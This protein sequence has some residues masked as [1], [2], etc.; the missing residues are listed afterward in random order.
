M[1]R[2]K[3]WKF[4]VACLAMAGILQGTGAAGGTMAAY[5]QEETGADA[6]KDLI[7]GLA[8]NQESFDP[9]TAET[10]EYREPVVLARALFDSLGEDEQEELANDG[11]LEELEMAEAKVLNLWIRDTPLDAV[12]DG[13][14]TWIME[15][16]YD[17]LV[18]ALGEETAAELI[19]L[20]ET[21]FL[22]YN[23]LVPQFQ[24]EKR[25]NLEEGL[26][27][28]TLIQEMDPE[29][30][31]AV[32]Q[33]RESYDALTEMQQAYV[34]H[35]S[36]LKNAEGKLAEAQG[37]AAEDTD[38][39]RV[40]SSGVRSSV[41]GL[42]DQWLLPEQWGEITE[43]MQEW[44]PASQPVL[45]WIVGHLSD[46]GCTL[47]F[48]PSQEVDTEQLAEQY[49]Y[50]GEP[51]RNNHL[52]HEE[53]FDYFDQHGIKV[54]LQ[55][56]PGFADVDTL[57]DL[58]LQQY[59]DHECVAGCGVDV[60]WYYGIT[61]DSG[62][63]V[64]DALAEKWDT[65]LK[66]L[67][68]DYRLFLKH[69]N[70]RYLPSTYRSDILF[71]D[72]SQG[73]GSMIGDVLGIYDENVDDVLGFV[74]E[75]KRFADAFPE[76]EVLYQIGYT[77]DAAWYN[78]LEDPVVRSLGLRLAEVTKQNCGIIWVDFSIK[79]PMTFPQTMTKDDKTNA[80][81][82]LLS[83]L[84]PSENGG[85]NIIGRRLAGVSTDAATAR[86][87]LYVEKMREMVD[88]LSEEEKDALDPEGLS[89]LENA[90]SIVAAE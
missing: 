51:D 1:R 74:P 68:P 27:V 18:E 12:E 37:Q 75:F 69:Y 21:K 62:L 78:T 72:D 20:Y 25:T 43:Q 7:L 87:P 86:D 38:L 4:A 89:Y 45:V 77:A 17:T 79:Y 9:D 80:I 56:E 29:D 14:V 8:I 63:P 48:T 54:Y 57:M 52:S 84:N 49:I 76:N 85:D 40:T 42:G 13:G 6:V 46:M 39:A 3:A 31:E 81:N 59:G 47:E 90:E 36:L 34:E 83:Y 28:D 24:E 30:G 60:E 58:I 19:P 55:V 33:V 73:F 23:D 67:N 5:A 35:Y 15:E 50:F 11:T 65:H 82:E 44:Y 70:I 22:P 26:R 64:T 88:A 66:E 41:Y 32:A 10:S 16:R 53:Y 61:D 71:V 2:R